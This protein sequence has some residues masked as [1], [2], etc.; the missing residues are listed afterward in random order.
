LIRVVSVVSNDIVTDNR[1]HKIAVTL[2]LNGYVVKIVGRRLRN[3]HALS[4]RPYAAK[5]FRLLFNKGPL[6]YFFLNVRIFFYL[7]GT[8]ANIILSND[9]DTL[10][11]CFL[12]SRITRRQLVFDSHELFPEVPELVNR[13]RIKKIWLML[14][15]YLICRIHYGFTVSN[16]IAE[17]YKKTYD[18]AFVTIRNLGRFRYDNEF[19]GIVKEKDT[20]IILYQ[21]SLNV[22]RGLELAIE[23]MQYIEGAKLRILGGGDIKANLIRL[24]EKLRLQDK[25]EFIGR[26]PMDLLWKYTASADVGISL[27]ENMG[28]NYMYSLPNKLFDYI[29]A[30]IPVIISDLPEMRAII[31]WYQIGKVLEERTPQKLAGTYR[32]VFGNLTNNKKFISKIELA[33]RELCWEREEDKLVSLFKCVSIST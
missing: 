33:A 26:V 32:E 15:R 16:S 10:L 4:K 30:R 17:Y 11:G 14:E 31:D 29:Q 22:G 3:S 1:I 21:G 24:T 20:R 27:E 8:R 13:P 9:L 12:A 23:S 7:L 19:E 5:R 25:V 2:G 6:F 18:V 28:L